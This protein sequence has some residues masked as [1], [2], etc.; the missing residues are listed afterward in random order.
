[1][2]AQLWPDRIPELPRFDDRLERFV[3]ASCGEPLTVC[4]VRPPATQLIVFL[5]GKEQCR[6]LLGEG[7]RVEIGRR[8]AKG[9]IGLESRLGTDLVAA[10]SRHHVAFAR[11]AGRVTVED[12]GSRN[13][14][15]VR[16]SSPPDGT[17]T[18]SPWP[19]TTST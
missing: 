1:L 3:C 13:G 19:S 10:V 6:F 16:S 7:Q 12:L 18:T 5:H 17:R 9:C 14:T 4:D 15:V 2:I 11:H 8:D